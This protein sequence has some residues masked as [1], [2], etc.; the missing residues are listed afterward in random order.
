MGDTT[1]RDFLIAGGAA[2]LALPAAA[3]AA[4]KGS[5]VARHGHLQ[6]KGSRVVDAHGKPVTLRGMSLFWSQW[7]PQFYN[8]GV[9]AWLRKDWHATIVRAAIAAHAGG[10][11]RNPEAETRKAE[12]VIGAAIAEG[13]YVVLDWHAHEPDADNCIKLFT[14]I[15]AKYR[16]V[17]NILYETYNEP[18]PKHGWADL[19]KPYHARV[20]EAVRAID[21]RAFIIAGTR[22]WTQDVDEAAADPLR[23]DNVAYA[24]HY[25]AATHKDA[26]RRKG[27]LA[28]ERGAAL[29]V[30]E[31]GITHSSGNYPINVEEARRWWDWCDAHGIS[32]LAWSICEKDEASAALLPGAAHRGGW[33]LSSLSYAGQVARAHL[34][35]KQ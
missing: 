3:Y 28:M 17:P 22:S 21:P 30:T 24:L 2:A 9:V 20:I 8:R 4:P 29:F 16:G 19:L 10:Y 11:N 15:A 6:V 31:Y 5:P 27:E 13:I 7:M 18:L 12:A 14:H 26:L 25:Y 1:R 23:Y 34:R 33:P 32:Y 35:S